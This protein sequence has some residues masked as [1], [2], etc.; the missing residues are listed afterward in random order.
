MQNLWKTYDNITGILRK[1]KSDV[2][3]ETHYQRLLL[4]EYLELKITDNQSY[5]FLRML[6]KMTYHFPKKI[7]GSRISLT[8]KRLMKILRQT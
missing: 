7:L 2:I 8:Y 4:V 3:S 1:R 6:S 5:D